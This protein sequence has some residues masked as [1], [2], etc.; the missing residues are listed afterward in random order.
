MGVN[1]ACRWT[2][3]R[4]HLLPDTAVRALQHERAPT[5]ALA[6]FDSAG[7]AKEGVLLDLAQG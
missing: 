5:V 1:V 6:G 7:G 4:S 3:L 2:D